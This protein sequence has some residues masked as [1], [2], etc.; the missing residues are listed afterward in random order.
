[1]IGLGVMGSNLV[2]NMAD[3]GFTIA[4]Y[5]AQAEKGDALR[6]KNHPRVRVAASLPEL[7][8]LLKPPRRVM[9]LVPAGKPV[10]SVIQALL[11]LHAPGDILIDGGNSHFTDTNARL[12]MLGERQ[13]DF[14]GVGISGG[15]EG[16]RRGP[17]IMPGGRRDAYAQVQAIFAAV[18]AKVGDEPCVTYL[19]PGAAGHYVKMVHNGIEYGLMEI[20]AESY[21]LLKRGL[22]FSNDEL[23]ALYA[24]WNAG[25]LGGFLME[26]TAHIFQQPD[27][28]TGGRLI[29]MIRDVARQ[30]G[31][32]MW[33][34]Q[35]A[36]ALHVPVTLIDS[37]VEMRDL[38]A[39][40]SERKAAGAL[41][42]N[43]LK[44]PAIPAPPEFDRAT[45]TRQLRNAVY[46]SMLVTYAQGLRQLAAAAR[47]YQY[48]LPLAPLARIWRGGCII[49]AALLDDISAAYA[50]N[51]HLENLL[52]DPNIAQALSARQ[53]DL[54]AVVTRAIAQGIPAAALTS[55]LT[56]YDAL[57]SPTLPANLIQAQRDFFGAHTYERVD[58]DGVFHTEWDG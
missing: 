13:I 57:R 48:D 1:M 54:R 20:I 38:T 25:E 18:A 56:Y 24:E 15:E 37:A 29:D 32:G 31:T 16:A 46:F 39:L 52:L 35:D 42:G 9:L 26:I 7:L 5:D 21:D 44:L 10:D 11:P 49:R 2:L 23:H 3:H 22:G 28:L 34:S 33:A 53:Q 30:K 47:A 8:G 12:Q 51:P 4:G 19:G 6:G 36:M 40:E 50:Q 58:R 17:C 14:L 41:F 45:V 27:P 43:Q 55:A